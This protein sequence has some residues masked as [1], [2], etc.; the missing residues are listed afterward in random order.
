VT[1][2]TNKK[3][4][5]GAANVILSEANNPQ[6]AAP[7]FFSLPISA[8]FQRKLES[9]SIFSITL[10]LFP[11]QIGLSI[12]TSVEIENNDPALISRLLAA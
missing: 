9:Q 11:N 3:R 7:L 6:H 5:S 10:R 2:L 12:L 4:N 1:S 8:S